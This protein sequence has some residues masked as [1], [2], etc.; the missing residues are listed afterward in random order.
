MHLWR[1]CFSRHFD[2]KNGQIAETLALR[3]D[4]FNAGGISSNL[5]SKRLN[6]LNKPVYI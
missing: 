4:E 6:F 3:L 5:R 2:E 1:G